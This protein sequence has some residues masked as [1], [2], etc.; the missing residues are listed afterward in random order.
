MPHGR[1]QTYAQ[2]REL[3]WRWNPIGIE[4]D[5]HNESEYDTLAGLVFALVQRGETPLTIRTFVEDWM[6]RNLSMTAD[7]VDAFIR[8]VAD[9]HRREKAVD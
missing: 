5:L 8:E 9:W 2:L 7:G 3:A 4:R 6:S 1:D